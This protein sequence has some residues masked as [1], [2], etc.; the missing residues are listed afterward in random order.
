MV[1]QAL[2]IGVPGFCNAVLQHGQ[3]VTDPHIALVEGSGIAQFFRSRIELA[4]LQVVPGQARWAT[5]LPAAAT[6]GASS[7]VSFRY[8]RHHVFL[9]GSLE[10]A[11]DSF[12]RLAEDGVLQGACNT[13]QG[14]AV[15][16]PSRHPRWGIL[17]LP[18]PSRRHTTH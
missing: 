12:A 15:G 16:G 3:V 5:S 13:Q 1:G 11:R 2:N 7:C 17:V 8:A 6:S 9:F 18:P 10:L 14:A 4:M